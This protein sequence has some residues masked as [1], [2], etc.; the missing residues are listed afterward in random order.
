MPRSKRR[1]TGPTALTNLHPSPTAGLPVSRPVDRYDYV[2]DRC[3]GQRVLDLGAY[4]DTEFGRHNHSSWRWLHAEIAS[5]AK[6]VLGVDAA[7]AVR[8]AGGVSTPYATRIV[9]GTVE[10]LSPSWRTSNPT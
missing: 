1:R 8:E 2:R 7:E 5:V 3:V 10:H 9:Y 4:D 6:E